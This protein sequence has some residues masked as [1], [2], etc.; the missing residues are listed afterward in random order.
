MV[1]DYCTYFP[2]SIFPLHFWAKKVRLE[3]GDYFPL[4]KFLRE[5]PEIMEKWVKMATTKNAKGLS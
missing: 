1:T 5:V 3:G 2:P 4:L